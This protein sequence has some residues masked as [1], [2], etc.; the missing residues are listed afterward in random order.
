MNLHIRP[1]DIDIP[2]DKLEY[3]FARSSGP[4]GQNVN[5]VNTKAEIRFTVNEADWIPNEV[6]SRLLHYQKNKV[7]NDGELVIASQEHRTQNKNR[8]D[9]IKKLQVMLAEAYLEPK[10]REMFEG[11]SEKG[12]AIMREDKRKRGAVKANRKVRFDDD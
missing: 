11:R 4:G 10:E 12:K 3:N 9:C 7:N 5:K 8:E 1:D 2:L 6:K